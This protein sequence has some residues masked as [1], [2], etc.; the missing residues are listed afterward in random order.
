MVFCE[1]LQTIEIPQYFN[2]DSGLEKNSSAA[3]EKQP[4]LPLFSCYLFLLNIH[5]IQQTF[6]KFVD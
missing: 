6:F 1:M 3:V 5:F 4:I 2:M